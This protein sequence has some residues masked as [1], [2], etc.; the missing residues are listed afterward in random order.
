MKKTTLIALVFSVILI[1]CNSE[2]EVSINSISG[3]GIFITQVD[4]GTIEGEL[5]LP[6]GQGPFPTLIIVPG[7]GNDTREISEPF[8]S[9]VNS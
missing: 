5:F 6:D 8:V 9:I 1:S 4:N 7:S 2:D 3:E